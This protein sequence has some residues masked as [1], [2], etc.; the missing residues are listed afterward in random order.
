MLYLIF[1]VLLIVL[2]CGVIG[3]VSNQNKRAKMELEQARS[4][5]NTDRQ[6]SQ[7]MQ[8]K[9]TQDDE[10][11]TLI[12]YDEVVRAAYEKVAPYGSDP[13]LELKKAFMVIKDKSKLAKVA[14]Q[15][16]SDIESGKSFELATSSQSKEYKGFLIKQRQDGGFEVDG[17]SFSK[18]KD[19]QDYVDMIKWQK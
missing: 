14:D 4:R 12:K 11:S 15:I 2:V 5:Q 3:M 6:Y 1:L 19:A 18:L 16:V 13:V 8:Q 7:E 17:K 10:W 9:L